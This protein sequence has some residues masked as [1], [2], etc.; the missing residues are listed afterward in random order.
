MVVFDG[1]RGGG[2]VI[3]L[4]NAVKG[5]LLACISP[6]HPLIGDAWIERIQSDVFD[7]VSALVQLQITLVCVLE[8]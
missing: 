5:R 6:Q 3:A 8:V 2:C 7:C 1:W 4:M